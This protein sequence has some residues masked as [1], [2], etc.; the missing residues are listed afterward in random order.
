MIW[1]SEIRPSCMPRGREQLEEIT[2][3]GEGRRDTTSESAESKMRLV[4][5]TNIS[6][7]LS[8]NY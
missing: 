5:R 2:G 4:K 8:L 7:R 3:T 1:E 6:A